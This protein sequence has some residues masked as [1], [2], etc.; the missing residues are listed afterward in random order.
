MAELDLNMPPIGTDH[1]AMTNSNAK[2][3]SFRLN[4]RRREGRRL[5][6]ALKLFCNTAVFVS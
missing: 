2:L 5:F 4:P 3:I 1:M 6:D